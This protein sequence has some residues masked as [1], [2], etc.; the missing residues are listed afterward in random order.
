M[1]PCTS[2]DECDVF[3]LGVRCRV[4]PGGGQPGICGCHVAFRLDPTTQECVYVRLVVVDVF[5][6][7]MLYFAVLAATYALV[8]LVRWFKEAR[9]ARVHH[10]DRI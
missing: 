3:G 1:F 10:Y 2:H 6:M 8:L 5:V 4:P 9:F 7:A